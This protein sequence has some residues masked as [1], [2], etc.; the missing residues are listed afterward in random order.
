M[1]KGKFSNPRPYREE[2]REIE[3]SFRQLTGQ[4]KPARKEDPLFSNAAVPD[5]NN[6]DPEAASLLSQADSL[7][8]GN[9]DPF[10]G[11]GDSF[12]GA[13]DPFSGADDPFSGADGLFSEPEPDSPAKEAGKTPKK[14]AAA[15]LNQVFS[16]MDSHQKPVMVALCAAALILIISLI[17]IFFVN[18]SGDP[19]GKKILNNVTVAGVN[20]GGMSKSDAISA[21]KSATDQ[22]YTVQDMV[23]TLGDTTLRLSPKDTGAK[24]DVK[25]A[26]AAAYDYGR[27][28]TKAERQEA[29]K[30][31]L[32]GVHTIGLLPYLNLD[33]AYIKGVLED[34]AGNTGTLLTQTTYTLEGTVP[35]LGTDKFNKDTA[36]QLT[37]VITMGTPGIN[38]NVDN[39][40]NQ[41]LD[42]YSLNV[43]TVEAADAQA[44]AEPDPVDLQKIYDEICVKPVDAT[45]NMQTFK[46]IPGSY[47][48]EFDL[49]QAQKQVSSAKDG[50]VVRIPMEYVAPEILDDDVFFRDVLGSARTPHSSNANRTNNLELACA[51][52]NGLVLNPGE[53]F[54]F[55]DTL[56]ERTAAKGYKSAPAYSGNDLVNQVGGGI[57]QVSST[58]YCSTLLADL[59]IV[60]RTNH[61]FPVSYI[62]YG[63]D[64]TVSWR[65]P[66]FKFRNST[67]YPI[68]IEAEVS[69]GY[70]S[71]QILGTDEK[72]YYVEMSYVISE[73]YK[74]DTE[75][76]D[77]KANNAEGYKDGDVIEEGTTGYLVKTYK[78]K[79]N[80]ATG[81]LISKDFV[82]NSQYKTVNRVV[83]RV[84][85]EPT[86]PSTAPSTEPSTA[87]T[88]PAPSTEPSTAPT[89]PSTEPPATGSSES[90]GTDLESDSGG[91]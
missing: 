67:N 5:L 58:L 13:D 14:T 30:A 38:F 59:E 48:Y 44:S 46:A 45:M 51:A 28:G 56:G 33:Q 27:T 72:D 47:G 34:Y 83:A 11:A 71:I 78:S 26:V 1:S 24:L 80:R 50:E 43:F 86:E 19:Y 40:F 84:E 20:V 31:S 63:M 91:E 2:E 57:C 55:N 60:A 53:T 77:F 10:S 64:A 79:Y 41:I 85:A 22:T 54:S 52:L 9:D 29:Y 25:A 75:Y 69:G 6:A 70:V 49:V 37:L 74:P 73:T 65:S 23:V 15:F 18:I 76:K 82:A 7:I 90:G 39:L 87:P 3:K 8:P 81:V 61:G 32:T 89:T 17:A 35:E 62:D 88:T 4:E 68:K 21:V 16:F 42:A 66:D 36:P 12:S